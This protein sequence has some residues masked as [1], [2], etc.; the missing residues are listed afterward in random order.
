MPLQFFREYKNGI[1]LTSLLLQMNLIK[2]KER[3]KEKKRN[4]N[5]DIGYNKTNHLNS[6][7][8]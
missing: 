4:V 2:K 6:P 1:L 5:F 3:I 7:Q 8:Y